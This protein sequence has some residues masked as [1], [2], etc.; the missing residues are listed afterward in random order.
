MWISLREI[1]AVT[2][3][4]SIPYSVQVPWK[5]IARLSG[6]G[7]HAHRMVSVTLPETLLCFL[8]PDCATS[9]C[10]NPA[11]PNPSKPRSRPALGR[12]SAKQVG[13]HVIGEKSPSHPSPSWELSKAPPDW[14]VGKDQVAYASDTSEN[15]FALV[16]QKFFL[17][18][19]SFSILVGFLRLHITCKGTHHLWA[20]RVIPK[21]SEPSLYSRWKMRLCV[22]SNLP[23]ILLICFVNGSTSAFPNIPSFPQFSLD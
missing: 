3:A 18:W 6:W 7:A 11:L 15:S 5:A 9:Y 4:L 21:R 1:S 23:L 8:P 19:E 22:L 17:A 20:C 13:S 12:H 2:M 14:A 16:L 10:A